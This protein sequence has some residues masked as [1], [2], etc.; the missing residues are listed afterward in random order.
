MDIHNNP[1]RNHADLAALAGFPKLQELVLYSSRS[2]DQQK[3]STDKYRARLSNALP[4]IKLLDGQATEITAEHQSQLPCQLAAPEPCPLASLINQHCKEICI[5]PAVCD[6]MHSHKVSTP[7]VEQQP[8]FPRT[9]TVLQEFRNRKQPLQV[10]D[11]SLCRHMDT[12]VLLLKQSG[13][14][15]PNQTKNTVSPDDLFRILVQKERQESK[16]EKAVGAIVDISHILVQTNCSYKYI[17]EL[18]MNQHKFQIQ[19]QAL[20]GEQKH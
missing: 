3:L 20:K 1:I 6:R 15:A 7:W 11:K 19:I 16:L 18:E 13:E 4:Q 2:S 14:N 5:A 17:D 8:K 10:P 12:G 9:E